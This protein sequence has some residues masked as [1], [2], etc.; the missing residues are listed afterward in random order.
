[1]ERDNHLWDVSCQVVKVN[2]FKLLA[3]HRCG[4]ESHQGLWIL[5][6]EESIQL[7][8]VT[9]VVLLKQFV[10]EIMLKATPEIRFFVSGILDWLT[11]FVKIMS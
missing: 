11:S 5:S 3:P 6:C 8:N 7:A 2:D 9:S 1:M 10:L 4:L